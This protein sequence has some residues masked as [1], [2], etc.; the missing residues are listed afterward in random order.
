[1]TQVMSLDACAEHLDLPLPH[2]PASQRRF[3]DAITFGTPPLSVNG[4][5]AES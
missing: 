3:P 2:N 4:I 1:M 5:W